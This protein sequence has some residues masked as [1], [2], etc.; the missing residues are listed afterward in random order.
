MYL[1][2]FNYL[3]DCLWDM[4]TVNNRP[5]RRHWSII[6]GCQYQEP[7]KTTWILNKLGAGMR[8]NDPITRA[9]TLVTWKKLIKDMFHG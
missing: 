9:G 4:T 5:M 3:E 2:G 6:G 8:S 1:W 7:E